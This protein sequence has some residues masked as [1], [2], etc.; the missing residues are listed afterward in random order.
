M[1][2]IGK[3]PLAMEVILYLS[4][5]PIMS[6]MPVILVFLVLD[7]I[8]GGHDVSRTMCS[9]HVYISAFIF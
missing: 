1:D 2:G 9:V 5:D 8:A 4:G 6:V 3:N 7:V